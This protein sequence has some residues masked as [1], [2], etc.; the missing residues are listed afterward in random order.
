MHAATRSAAAVLAAPS[1]V[2]MALA[3]AGAAAVEAMAAA[4]AEAK[5]AA[6]PVTVDGVQDYVGSRCLRLWLDA[7]D[8][9]ASSRG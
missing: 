1:S 9:V 2:Q 8:S 4:A 7:S 5:V 3:S 6:N